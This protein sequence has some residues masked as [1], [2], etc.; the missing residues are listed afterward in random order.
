MKK[1]FSI[2]WNLHTRYHFKLGFH[3]ADQHKGGKGFQYTKYHK[4]NQGKAW[5]PPVEY[6]NS[7]SKHVIRES[8]GN[9]SNPLFKGNVQGWKHP[10][11]C[12]F[13]QPEL[14]SYRMP[15]RVVQIKKWP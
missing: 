8:E 1:L 11:R 4:D 6:P 2:M 12:A 10:G 14:L 13:A 3:K 15:K 7:E 9:M 5:N